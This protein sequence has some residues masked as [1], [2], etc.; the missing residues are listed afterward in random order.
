MF[1]LVCE[2]F[3]RVGGGV[4]PPSSHTTVRTVRYT[5]VHIIQSFDSIL[6]NAIL[7]S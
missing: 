2:I 7:A 3:Y 1:L 5:A 6:Y 4:K